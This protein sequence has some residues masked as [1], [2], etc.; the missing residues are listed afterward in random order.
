[1]TI[2]VELIEPSTTKPGRPSMRIFL[3]P[4][5]C[6]LWG[7]FGMV[8]PAA[9]IDADDPG[10]WVDE[11]P[12]TDFDQ[13]SV[14]FDEIKNGGPPK[15]GIPPIDDPQFVKLGEVDLPDI[16]P[17]IGVII[18]GTARAYPIRMLIWHEIVNDAIGDVPIAVTFCPL[19]NTGIVFDRRLD[20]AGSRLWHDRQ[21]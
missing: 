19:C 20:G 12:N 10:L 6:L 4:L 3:L 9:A 13:A 21:A 14:S 5:F 15:D 18:N 2:L 17:V 11:W 1:M 8:P 16:E 7:G